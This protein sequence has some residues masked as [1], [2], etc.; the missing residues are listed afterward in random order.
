MG[1]QRF[2][3]AAGEDCGGHAVARE[4]NAVADSPVMVEVAEVRQ[5]FHGTVDRAGPAAD[6]RHI[7]QLWVQTAQFGSDLVGGRRWFFVKV[8]DATGVGEL[9]QG[10][11]KHDAAIR[12]VAPVVEHGARVGHAL[13]AA[14]ADGVELGFHRGGCHHVAGHDGNHATQLGELCTPGV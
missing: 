10:L 5:A 9:A 2:D 4:A 12:G 1:G 6:N 13:T 8:A 11:T 3:D 14:E 7:L